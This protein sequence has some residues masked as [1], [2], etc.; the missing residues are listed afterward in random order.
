MILYLSCSC[1]AQGSSLKAQAMRN[2]AVP[3]DQEEVLDQA[4]RQRQSWAHVGAYETLSKVQAANGDEL[5][6]H[7]DLSQCLQ[8]IQ[9]KG[10]LLL[11]QVRSAIVK[12]V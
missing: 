7:F 10:E 1:L 5:A 4:L 11:T 9:P 6:K 12:V 2:A 3:V 8:N